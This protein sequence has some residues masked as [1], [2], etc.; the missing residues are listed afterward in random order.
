MGLPDDCPG[1]GQSLLLATRKLV[2][3]HATVDIVSSVKLCVTYLG[4]G[5]LIDQ[6]V[7]L[8]KSAFLLSLGVKFAQDFDLFVIPSLTE[9][10]DYLYLG[11]ILDDLRVDHFLSFLFQLY[12]GG[13]FNITGVLLN[14]LC[15]ELSRRHV[16]QEGLWIVSDSI[17][18]AVVFDE[19]RCIRDL[20]SF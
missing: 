13:P 15:L 8:F 11:K 14:D 4:Q 6:I 9:F 3:S 16:H 19:A 10:L 2:T 18:Q 12:L 5:S 17:L 1:D 20:Y 7:D